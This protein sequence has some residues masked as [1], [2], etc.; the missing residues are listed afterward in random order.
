MKSLP[1]SAKTL[2]VEPVVIYLGA[3]DKAAF[4]NEVNVSVIPVGTWVTLTWIL[5]SIIG[6]VPSL[7]HWHMCWLGYPTTLLKTYLSL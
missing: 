7:S 1:F 3:K 2:I 4:L 6:P 5:L